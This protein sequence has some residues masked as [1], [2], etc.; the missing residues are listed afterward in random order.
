[1]ICLIRNLTDIQI[2]STLPESS[3]T[4]LGDDLTRIHVYRNIIAHHVGNAQIN[5]TDFSKYWDD[6]SQVTI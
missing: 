1:M 3:Q 6:I 5:D 4:G 2:G